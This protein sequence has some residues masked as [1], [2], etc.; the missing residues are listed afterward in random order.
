MLQQIVQH[1]AQR[2]IAVVPLIQVAVELL[3]L[4]SKAGA[5]S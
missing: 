2:T 3:C 5:N 4:L 1:F